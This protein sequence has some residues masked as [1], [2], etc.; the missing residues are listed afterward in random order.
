MAITKKGKISTSEIVVNFFPNTN[1]SPHKISEYY[2]GGV[3][4]PNNQGNATIPTSGQIKW[5]D[6]YGTG[7]QDEYKFQIPELCTDYFYNFTRG[8][9]GWEDLQDNAKEYVGRNNTLGS[10]EVLCYHSY[11]EIT[12]PALTIQTGTVLGEDTKFERLYKNYASGSA[13][14]GSYQNSDTNNF[15]PAGY[16]KLSVPKKFKRL[17][18]VATGGGGSGSTAKTIYNSTDL[19]NKKLLSNVD[20]GMDGQET[21]VWSDGF[22][23]TVPGGK[24]GG[25][26]S[27]SENIQVTGGIKTSQV[28]SNADTPENAVYVAGINDVRNNVTSFANNGVSINI[29]YRD[30]ERLGNVHSAISINGKGGDSIYGIGSSPRIEV[31]FSSSGTEQQYTGNQ[32][33]LAGAGGNAGQHGGR[34]ID[35]SFTTTDGG[36]GAM[37]AYLGDFETSPGDI[38][39]IKVGRGGRQSI[40]YYNEWSTQNNDTYQTYSANSEGGEGRVELWGSYG[41]QFTTMTH[42]GWVLEDSDGYVIARSYSAG[43]SIKGVDN[44][45]NSTTTETKVKV[46]GGTRLVPR[47]Y[48][49]RFSSRITKNG[50]L[51]LKNKFCNI[52]NNSVTVRG[53]AEILTKNPIPQQLYIEPD[54]GSEIEEVVGNG[55]GWSG[56]D[57]ETQN[58]WAI[59]KCNVVFVTTVGSDTTYSSSAKFNLIESTSPEGWVGK[60]PKSIT[61]GPAAGTQEHVIAQQEVYELDSS[62][63]ES[64][65]FDGSTRE[66]YSWVRN[67]TEHVLEDNTGSNFASAGNSVFSDADLGTKISGMCSGGFYVMNNKTRFSGSIELPDDP[68][69]SDYIDLV[70]DSN[71]AGYNLL[72]NAQFAGWTASKKQNINLKINENVFVYGIQYP[73][74]E[75]HAP[76]GILNDTLGETKGFPTFSIPAALSEVVVTIN[77]YGKIIGLGGY[78]ARLASSHP[79]NRRYGHDGADAIENL[80]TGS[81]IINNYSTG[82]IAGGGGGGG[83]KNGANAGGGAGQ[84]IN[85]GHA[86]GHSGYWRDSSDDRY[87]GAQEGGGGLPGVQTGSLVYQYVHHSGD[88]RGGTAT[89]GG[90]GTAAG[91]GYGKHGGGGGWAASGGNADNYLGGSGGKAIIGNGVTLND[92]GG[93][94]YGDVV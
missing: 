86:G 4:V 69:I 1:S 76:G 28:N 90:Q 89:A 23:V 92:L 75:R 54:G 13:D 64:T 38:I 11:N 71:I 85:L 24:G 20:S 93:T 77:N 73:Y 78:G 26:S 7:V 53:I 59:P 12:I 67:G 62:G 52:G 5:S 83:I 58:N 30:N 82:W 43:T 8:I 72:E 61:L 63:L 57:E 39:H 56:A 6:F 48:F 81:V 66:L 60:S 14:A 87:G 46:L 37:T 55:Q 80:S 49:L 41:A 36:D 19:K 32:Q 31:P 3:N 22:S 27:S 2:M 18:I 91:E 40:E 16:W 65:M 70:V 51:E 25:L 50:D 74:V 44:L 15:F 79:H 45:Q 68:I 33:P 35:N 42:A 47:K 29:I 10:M 17:R 9:N 34:G 94:V 21:S 88:M 84:N